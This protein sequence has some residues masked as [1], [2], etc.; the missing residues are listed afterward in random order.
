MSHTSLN[1]SVYLKTN[2]GKLPCDKN[3]DWGVDTSK[4][5]V[6]ISNGCYATFSDA[7][8]NASWDCG[9]PNRVSSAKNYD[10]WG[11]DSQGLLWTNYCTLNYKATAH[12]EVGG[13]CDDSTCGTTMST[14]AKNYG[15]NYMT[16]YPKDDGQKITVVK[17]Y[18]SDQDACIRG[19]SY[20][21]HGNL[22]WVGR[23]CSG[24]FQFSNGRTVDASSRNW[25]TNYVP[26][27]EN[28]AN[29]INLLQFLMQYK[30]SM[31]AH[32]D[33]IK[34]GIITANKNQ[35]A[36]LTAID[37]KLNVLSAQSK[38]DWQA[39]QDQNTAY[40]QFLYTNMNA[41]LKKII[42]AEAENYKKYLYQEIS[43][44]NIAL[45]STLQAQLEKENKLMQDYMTKENITFKAHM[46]KENTTLKAQL[47][48][49][50]KA[51][52]NQL[53]AENKALRKAQN[54]SIGNIQAQID[55]L[56]KQ[57]AI[58]SS[59]VGKNLGKDAV[60]YHKHMQKQWIDLDDSLQAIDDSLKNI[61]SH[62]HINAELANIRK[63]IALGA[64]V[65]YNNSSGINKSLGSIAASQATQTAYLGDIMTTQNTQGGY[66]DDILDNQ[67]TQ[68]GYLTDIMDNQTTMLGNQST[69]MGNQNSMMEAQSTMLGNQGTMMTN[70]NTMLGNQGTMMKNQNSMMG[71]QSTMMTNQ[72]TMLGNQGTMMKNQNSM[73]GNQSTM[74]TNQNT[75]LGNQGTM[76]G[77]Q[78]TMLAN[79]DIENGYLTDILTNQDSEN[80]SLN[81][82]INNQ[83]I[84]LTHTKNIST[85]I[86]LMRQ[87]LTSHW[88]V[89]D[90]YLRSMAGISN[91][92]SNINKTLSSIKSEINLS[93]I[94]AGI[95]DVKSLITG[96]F[97][98]IN[99]ELA[100]ISTN[101]KGVN[102]TLDN[103]VSK[104]SNIDSIAKNI[105]KIENNTFDN[106]TVLKQLQ[107]SIAELHDL[108]TV[109]QNISAFMQNS[110][111]IADAINAIDTKGRVIAKNIETLG[112]PIA[113]LSVVVAQG[114]ASLNAQIANLEA[115]MPS[116]WP[117]WPTDDSHSLF[118]WFVMLILVVL[119]IGAGYYG[120]K[121]YQ[122]YRANHPSS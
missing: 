102:T 82:I 99:T 31:L 65:A 120:F 81:T 60:S 115:K 27:N 15:K 113:E 49:E 93:G 52:K 78:S 53:I 79:Q 112:K 22:L 17:Q 84:Q 89:I 56:G 12:P 45:L 36:M 57:I 16:P 35:T 90:S 21:S 43:A 28:Y 8:Q 69:M 46:T 71:N 109:M 67:N 117:K 41:N 24:S 23:G 33:A 68:S 48:S 95:K 116:A 100:Y 106:K 34:T 51:L 101:V 75:M 83:S 66:L 55:A 50:N 121:K 54:E 29:P 118:M 62:S 47:I 58:I 30:E 87:S 2:K 44:G 32:W 1:D 6:W 122:E 107:Y 40:R 103:L 59:S 42:S 105:A 119:T 85:A 104:L 7:A 5:Q 73:M 25:E 92:I 3:D 114:V 110:H 13:T 80:A 37:T 39:V 26:M 9:D 38:Q 20:G 19:Y 86:S 63:D 77:N 74:M 76:L 72:N 108:P 88:L 91:E 98:S 94:Y 96:E 10:E 11:T 61:E 97:N 14:S 64:K 4:K 111:D 18:S 70:Q